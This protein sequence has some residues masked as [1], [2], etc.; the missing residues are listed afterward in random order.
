MKTILL[1][2]LFSSAVAHAAV[3][4]MPMPRRLA[5]KSGFYVSSNGFDK[6]AIEEMHDASVRKEGYRLEV[7]GERIRTWASSPAGACGDRPCLRC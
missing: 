1:S 4:L 3:S 2:V 5:E 7:T 6:V